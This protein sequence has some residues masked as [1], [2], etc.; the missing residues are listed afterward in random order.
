MRIP[1]SGRRDGSSNEGIRV[2]LKSGLTEYP[3]NIFNEHWI[4]G[5]IQKLFYKEKKWS[6][7]ILKR[8]EEEKNGGHINPYF[9]CFFT[10][11]NFRG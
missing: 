2:A 7:N 3:V 1:L 4:T 11:P 6:S 8:K 9:D 5:Q 10:T